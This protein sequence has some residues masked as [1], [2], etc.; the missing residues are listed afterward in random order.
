[1]L[2]YFLPRLTLTHICMDTQH[3]R[4]TCNVILRHSVDVVVNDM[5]HSVW[6][7]RMVLPTW[8]GWKKKDSRPFLHLLEF[9][10]FRIN[11]VLRFEHSVMYWRVSTIYPRRGKLFCR[12][13]LLRWRTLHSNPMKRGIVNEPEIVALRSAYKNKILNGWYEN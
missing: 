6:C 1:M 5:T 3:P 8:S 13:L 7:L 9:I 10:S 12:A 11:N 2:K 4:K